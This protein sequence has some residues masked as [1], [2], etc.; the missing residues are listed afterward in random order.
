MVSLTMTRKAEPLDAPSGELRLRSGCHGMMAKPNPMPT[1][2]YNVPASTLRVEE[3]I[4]HSRFVTTI[5]PAATVE[6][7]VVVH[8]PNRR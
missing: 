7:A 1:T 6:D 3:E 4:R 8:P 2:R 5:G